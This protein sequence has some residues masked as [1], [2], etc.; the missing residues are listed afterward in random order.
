MRRGANGAGFLALANLCLMAIIMQ[1]EVSM[2]SLLVR[3]MDAKTLARLKARALL[4]G[5]SL[6]AE[7]RAILEAEAAMSDRS[8]WLLWLE[9]FRAKVGHRSGPDAVALVRESRDER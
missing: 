5:R 9:A 2:T 3:D 1:A 4:N 6:Q 8:A 7:V